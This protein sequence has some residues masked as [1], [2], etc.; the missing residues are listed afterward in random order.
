MRNSPS[1]EMPSTAP[2]NGGCKRSMVAV[3]R[4]VGESSAASAAWANAGAKHEPPA[5]T[6]AISPTL[7]EVKVNARM[8]SLLSIW[9]LD[10][11]PR[12]RSL[13]LAEG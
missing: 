5:H 1:A 8:A 2:K 6:S 11:R 4:M 10:P 9:S 7:A 12:P 3:S 13:V